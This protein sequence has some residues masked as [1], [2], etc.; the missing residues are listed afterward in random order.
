VYAQ[1]SVS[2]GIADVYARE[3]A[4]LSA[5]LP[6]EI[7]EFE[8]LVARALEFDPLQPDALHLSAVLG[9]MRGEPRAHGI[10]ALEQAL[11][12]SG[13]RHTSERDAV[14]LLGRMMLDTG[15]P[16]RTIA[17]LEPLYEAN[18]PDSEV[19]FQLAQAFFDL[20][21]ARRGQEFAE[22]G[23]QIFADDPRFV[24]LLVLQ[25]DAPTAMRLD[26]L[27]VH[28]GHEDNLY[29]RAVLHYVRQAADRLDRIQALELYEASGGA[30]PLVH[31]F[32]VRRDVQ[33]RVDAFIESG[34]LRDP[35]AFGVFV[36]MLENDEQRELLRRQ[37]RSITGRFSVDT[38]RTG[39][40]RVVVEFDDGQLVFMRLDDNNDG[41]PDLELRIDPRSGLPVE[42]AIPSSN[43][44][45]EYRRYPE[46]S[47]VRLGNERYAVR[48]G[49]LRVRVFASDTFFAQAPV[50]VSAQFPEST[51]IDIP[52]TDTILRTSYLRETE[53]DG[54]V[55]TVDRIFNGQVLMRMQDT[56]E[57]GRTDLVT[58]FEAGVAV[59]AIRDVLG[60]GYFEVL[61]QYRDGLLVMVGLDNTQDGI[62]DY[63]ERYE[64]GVLREWDV[65]ADRRVDI[66]EQSFSD[67][68]RRAEFLRFLEEPAPP[69]DRLWSILPPVF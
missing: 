10:E 59:R 63:I 66:R 49:L 37:T 39:S 12:V 6:E 11:S 8:T 17:V 52:S 55:T 16:A 2:R 60:D 30:D 19:V 62:Y 40:E 25:D 33:E 35:Y 36:D 69:I 3:A 68:T 53:V 45:F 32:D 57:N 58:Y 26:E 65:N 47:S 21:N 28:E 18:N 50:S 29:R 67:S 1:D 4:L 51:E 34:G 23:R 41:I 14:L 20:G 56:D 31:A 43:Q 64:N 27:S 15:R 48:P 22:Y 54:R 13:F 5:D 7:D 61:E 42:A 9:R 24:S 38:E 46:V 44:R